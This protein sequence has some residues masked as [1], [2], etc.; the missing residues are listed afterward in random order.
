MTT[1]NVFSEIGFFSFTLCKCTHIKGVCE[2][3]G[4]WYASMHR[5]ME[6]PKED[7]IVVFEVF[8]PCVGGKEKKKNFFDGLF[9]RQW[10]SKE[11]KKERKKEGP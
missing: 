7:E 9:L 1:D 3:L 5:H 4:P 6:Q 8:L 2:G 10:H 11:R